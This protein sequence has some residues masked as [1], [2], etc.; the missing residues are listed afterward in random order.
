MY[1]LI[2]FY[3]QNR[4]QIFT[5]ILIIVFVIALIQLLNYL[6]KNRT[7]NNLTENQNISSNVVSDKQELISNKSAIS[8]KSISETKLQKD[9]DVIDKFIEYCNKKDIESAYELLTSNC[10]EV[11]FP[12]IEDFYNIYYINIYGNGN[13]TYTIE[14]W[15]GDTYQVNL[16]EDILSTGKINNTPSKQD[17]ITVVSEDGENKLNINNYIKRNNLNKT[18][19][20]KDIKITVTDVD[21]YMDYEIYNLSIENNSNNTILLDTS[22]DTK[23]VYLLDSKNLKYYFY[24]NEIIQNKL[25]VQSNFKNNIQIKFSNSFSSSRNIQ[26]LVFS[27]FVLNYD[28]YS[29]LQ[30]KSQ[31]NDFIEFKVNI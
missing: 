19:E 7:E 15:S 17:Y 24:N 13:V 2:R 6:S 29:N 8:G 30:N 31:Y 27:K 23:S 3:N 5:I 22:D 9:T 16:T 20:Y 10:K 4:K 14:N 11:M 12:T 28:E 25:I 18:T 21:T 1:N 26:K